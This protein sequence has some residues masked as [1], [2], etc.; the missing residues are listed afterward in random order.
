[1]ATSDMILAPHTFR[2]GKRA[3]AEMFEPVEQPMCY[4]KECGEL[5]PLAGY[6]RNSPVCWRCLPKVDR[7]SL[8]TGKYI[9]IRGGERTA[10]GRR[11]LEE[12]MRPLRN[13]I[14]GVVT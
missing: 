14:K 2:H 11:I 8:Q 4:C 12:A 5:W 7:L 9:H 13:G 1:M 10:N 6:R 3:I